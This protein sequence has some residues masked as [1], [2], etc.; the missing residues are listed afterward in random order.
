V[1]QDFD[2]LGPRVVKREPK[3]EYVV[4]FWTLR[5]VTGRDVTCSAYRTETGLE[6][7][8]EYSPGELIASPL[9]RG[10]DADECVAERADA[11]RLTLI[12]KGFHEIAK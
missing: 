5:G 7:R 9:F 10:L 2:W 8:T 3:V 12:A 11:W 6:L 1:P 4:T